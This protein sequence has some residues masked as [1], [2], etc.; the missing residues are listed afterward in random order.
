MKHIHNIPKPYWS[1]LALIVLIS[2]TTVSCQKNINDALGSLPSASFTATPLSNNPNKIVVQSTSKNVFM[3]N[4][5]FGNGASASN[6]SDTVFYLSKGVYP[7]TLTVFGHGGYDTA[8]QNIT[9]ANDAAGVNIVKGGDMTNASDWQSLNTGG[10]QTVVAFTSGGAVFTS[11]GNS[12]GGLYQ[13]IQVQAGVKYQFSANVQG[14]P[15]TNTWF[16]IYF[17]TTAPV[18]G[19]DYTDNKFVSLNTWSGCGTGAFNGNIANIGCSGSGS[20]ANGIITFAQS[21]TVYLA[22]KAGCSG[23]SMGTGITISNVSL[24]QL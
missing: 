17:G 13:A 1:G 6:E 11:N 5:N 4:W 14:G 7:I 22:I 21:G 12:N 18:S 3:W 2:S 20:D 23:G 15:L 16:E 10:T 8:T 9:I 24:I 19:Q